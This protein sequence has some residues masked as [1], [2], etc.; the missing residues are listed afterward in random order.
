MDPYRAYMFTVDDTFR[1]SG[2][3]PVASHP[4]PGLGFWLE[5]LAVALLLYVAAFEFLTRS[6]TQPTSAQT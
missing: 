2:Y 4:G 6:K 1:N 3:V 5:V